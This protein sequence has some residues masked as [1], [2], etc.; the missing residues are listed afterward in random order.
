MMTINKRNLA[1]GATTMLL[2][3]TAILASGSHLSKSVALLK[4]NPKEVVE[5]V[6]QIVNF[7]YVDGTFNKKDW[8]AIRKKYVTKANYKTDAEA[9]KGV[10]A[11]LKTLGDP[12]TQFLDKKE[13]KDMQLDTAG[14]LIG[15]GIQLTQDP[16]TKQ[17]VV[18]SPIEDTPAAKAGIISKDVIIKIDDK[19]TK[20]MDVNKAVSLIRGQEN[21]SVVLTIKQGNQ[22][23]RHKLLRQKIEIHPV[24]AEYRP[25]DLGGI[26]YIRLNQFS[27]NAPDEMSM[28][29]KK[30]EAKKVNG[31]VLDLRG[32]PG[33]LLYGAIDIAKMWMNE[34]IIVSTRNRVGGCDGRSNNC[35]QAADGS[36]LT[37]KPLVVLVDGG[38][39]SASEILSGALQDN[40]RAQL[41]GS[42]TFGKGLVQAV[43]PL[44]DGSG[45]KVTIAKYFTPSG[46]DINKLGIKP[47]VNVPLSKKDIKALMQDRKRLATKKDPQYSKALVT[48]QSQ[49]A[50]TTKPTAEVPQPQ[51]TVEVS[52]P[53][54]T[55]AVPDTAK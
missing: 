31:Y 18:V 4:S 27:A 28:A 41:V 46:K 26:G 54:T 10:R 47:D 17:L 51:P 34:G 2:A 32:N 3:A 40:K 15:V 9:Y 16:K 20:G 33:G 14:N 19:S 50:R 42:K 30:M 36:A 11:M 49:I 5:E 43:R 48:L 53:Q 55:L 38:S 24:K 22:T 52:Q 39:A 8:N 12:Y 6:W 35:K 25:N 44:R 23:I 21:T 45:L 37:N 7:S 29:I 13:Y 1:L